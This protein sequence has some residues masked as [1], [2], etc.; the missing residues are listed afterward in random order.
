MRGRVEQILGAPPRGA[1]DRHLP[2]HRAPAA[3]AALARGRAH[4]GLPD[5]RFGRSAA[6]GRSGSSRPMTS[7]SRAGSRARS[8]GSS[9]R[10]RTRAGGRKD[11]KAGNDPTRA[12]M[13]RLYGLYEEACARAGRGRFRGA[14]AA[15]LRALARSSRPAGALPAALPA[16]AGRRVPGHQ[17]HPV[18]VAAPASLAPTATRS[19]SATTISRSTAGA[20][21]GWRICS[22]SAATTPRAKLYRL[23]Q[24]YRSTA[25]ILA[26]A[27]ALI[28]HNSGRLGKTLWTNGEPG[29]PIQLYAAFNERDEA[30]FV[31]RRVADY[32][33]A[34]RPAKRYRGPVPI[35]RPVARLRGSV[36]RGAHP[37]PCLWRTE[38]L[39]ARGDQ[40]RARLS[41]A[42]R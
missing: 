36:H 34:R 38:V 31:A 17:L 9:T 42:A 40:G 5:P 27:N 16:R 14:A 39:R 20:A 29:L 10:T 3:A 13:I 8:R 22:S 19:W 37:V 23:E 33:A 11:L 7:T 6:A 4:A 2:R 12:Q 25:A 1:L 41:A 32:V 24:N 35:Q 26:A 15:R 30:E 18:R 21:R 28:A